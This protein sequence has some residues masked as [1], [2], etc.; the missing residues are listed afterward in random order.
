MLCGADQFEPLRIWA[1]MKVL[2]YVSHLSRA[3]LD[4]YLISVQAVVK[5]QVL[6][7]QEAELRLQA[8]DQAR[9]AA[10]AR[11]D[12]L[13]AGLAA[14]LSRLSMLEEGAAA[15]AAA[16]GAALGAWENASESDASRD[17]RMQV[18][19]D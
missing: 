9:A 5:Q 13:A 19:V 1:L 18:G 3:D 7:V 10:E 15:T 12:A 2:S 6:H 11:A 14:A 17:D 8:L 16:A 4:S